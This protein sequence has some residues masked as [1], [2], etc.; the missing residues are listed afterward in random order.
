MI[1]Q[2]RQC[3][4]CDAPVAEVSLVPRTMVVQD[5]G[6][7][8]EASDEAFWEG[9]TVIGYGCEND[10]CENWQG[11]LANMSISIVGGGGRRFYTDAGPSLEEVAKEE[12]Q[13]DVRGEIVS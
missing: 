1:G 7:Y 13:S 4:R 5:D 8:D 12:G 11:N 3:K 6:A 9:E 10:R 2:V